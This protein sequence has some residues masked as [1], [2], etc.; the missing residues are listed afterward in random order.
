MTYWSNI[1]KSWTQRLHIHTNSPIADDDF[2]E[3]KPGVEI[4]D[5]HCSE[6]GESH[7]SRLR[8]TTCCGQVLCNHCTRQLLDEQNWNTGFFVCPF[9]GTK[10]SKHPR[11]QLDDALEVLRT[12]N[13]YHLLD[14]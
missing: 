13:Y 4:D 10:T 5:N 2:S 3:I 8:E 12:W 11:Q 14:H 6:C 1:A 9:C 7:T